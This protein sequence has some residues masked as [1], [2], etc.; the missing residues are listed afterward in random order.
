MRPN[1]MCW[2]TR[3]YAVCATITPG[4]TCYSGLALIFTLAAH[5][6]GWGT[7]SGLHG[8]IGIF[9]QLGGCTCCWDLGEV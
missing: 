8:N 1:E 5:C 4:R 7:T 3:S 6:W 2:F 9:S